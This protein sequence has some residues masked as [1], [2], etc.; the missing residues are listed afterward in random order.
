MR[1][2]SPHGVL[3]HT[4]ASS[5]ALRHATLVPISRDFVLPVPSAS[6]PPLPPLT[7][8]PLHAYF[9]SD[10]TSSET[11]WTS[12]LSLNAPPSVSQVRILPSCL[13]AVFPPVYISLSA[14]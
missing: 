6:N 3:P 13:S 12:H 9:S 8:G 2:T 10:V 7:P 11:F 5:L 14:R 1:V 4:K